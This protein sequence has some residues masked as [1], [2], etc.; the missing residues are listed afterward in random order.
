VVAARAQR[1]SVTDTTWTQ[2]PNAIF[3][4]HVNTAYGEKGEREP[5]LKQVF[6]HHRWSSNR[7]AHKESR[8][9]AGQWREQHGRRQQIYELQWTLQDAAVQK[10]FES[11]GGLLTCTPVAE[12]DDKEKDKDKDS[13]HS[14]MVTAEQVGGRFQ[15]LKLHRPLADRLKVIRRRTKDVFKKEQA[16]KTAN[17][18]VATIT[19]ASASEPVSLAPLTEEDDQVGATP[20][21][22][23][24][25]AATEA[26]HASRRDS[27]RNALVSCVALTALQTSWLEGEKK[28][29]DLAHEMA[30]QK[31]QED[32]DIRKEVNSDDQVPEVAPSNP[33]RLRTQRTT[34][35]FERR[36]NTVLLSI[37]AKHDGDR[38]D[39]LDHGELLTCLRDV[40]LRW[41]TEKERAAVRHIIWDFS[42]LHA[43]FDELVNQIIPAVRRVYDELRRPRRLEIFHEVDAYGK[44][45]V[46]VGETLDAL[47]RFG[48]FASDEVC[49]DAL[50]AF[51]QQRA[52]AD[53][54]PQGFKKAVL[55]EEGFI[56]FVAI[57]QE[58]TER[59]TIVQL[60]RIAQRHGLSNEERDSWQFELVNLN[61]MFH[62]YDPC[63][64]K[65]GSATGLLS[66]Q[67]FFTVLRESGYMPK[68][69]PK[70]QMLGELINKV[71]HTSGTFGFH[72][73]LRVMTVLR[74]FDRERLRKM[75]DTRCGVPNGTLNRTD[76]GHLLEDCG[77]VPKSAD[78]RA[79]CEALL[80]DI[81]DEGSGRAE[82]EEF[83]MLCQRMNAQ[84]RILQ[85]ER[86]RAYVLAAGWTE[87]HFHEFR[88][89]FQ[90]FDEDMSE[91]LERDEL[92]KAVDLLKDRYWQS[93]GNMNQILVV[94][95]ID[96]SKEVFGVPEDV[97]VNFLTFLR[98]LK[99]LD[100]GENRRQQ[101]AS[102]G[103][104]RER[105]DYFY[106]VYQQMDADSCT[107]AGLKRDVLEK[108]VQTT[109]RTHGTK[110]PAQLEIMLQISVEPTFVPFAGFLRIMKCIEGVVVDSDL[111]EVFK[112]MIRWKQ[113]SLMTAEIEDSLS[114]VSNVDP[115]LLRITPGDPNNSEVELGADDAENGEDDDVEEGEDPTSSDDCGEFSEQ[116]DPASS[117]G[118]T[119]RRE[120]SQMSTRQLD[121]PLSEEQPQQPQQPSSERTARG[122][123]KHW[124][125]QRSYTTNLSV[126]VD[127]DRQRSPRGSLC[128]VM[129]PVSPQ[130]PPEP[131]TPTRA[132]KFTRQGTF[133]Q[134]SARRSTKRSRP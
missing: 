6:I 48:I 28:E 95:G 71:Q 68:S 125:P 33:R 57:L 51:T 19:P 18:M 36:E 66:E 84:L 92:M 55:D 40:G 119:S 94:L 109:C 127:A 132:A 91:I 25:T 81:D 99:M 43:S 38:S 80:E 32:T 41:R 106:G 88:N 39:S 85:H 47:R 134:A 22:G 75:F 102:L 130:E 103:F 9:Q 14:K 24:A 104:T 126:T 112:D 118:Q 10:Q 120:E 87:H 123:S 60:Y 49:R 100:D 105:T 124:R 30:I 34:E 114:K 29:P 27:H 96:S 46:T 59:D 64:G 78:E 12:K 4:S 21:Q 67:Q 76:I 115:E 2:I 52:R 45:L 26:D 37:F 69:R 62:E 93:S 44:G 97:K 89:A 15:S 101:G 107:H 133:S 77:I 42:K 111:E 20:A 83:V 50:Y 113:I 1:P 70:Q 56:S 98:M 121:P 58:R 129:S 5:Q 90:A 61:K 13:E 16:R 8:R 73:F 122:G 63:S 116:A 72:D 86:E 11:R 108:A 35:K 54:L 74:E 128:G 17:S 3:R 110:K 65:Y 7:I 131:A 23:N 79:E 53:G 82:V 31:H 117:D